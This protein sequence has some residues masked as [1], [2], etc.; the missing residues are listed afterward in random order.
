MSKRQ[1][2]VKLEV[3]RGERFVLR[4][5]LALLT[6]RFPSGAVSRSVSLATARD[7]RRELRTGMPGGS[8][9]RDCFGRPLSPLDPCI[10]IVRLLKIDALDLTTTYVGDSALGL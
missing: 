7:P 10:N 5:P 6:I 8:G 2:N 4:E 1:R 9:S 3:V